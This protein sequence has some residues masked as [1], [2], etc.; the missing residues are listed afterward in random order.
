M[1]VPAVLVSLRP[2]VVTLVA[3]DDSPLVTAPRNG[4]AP[5]AVAVLV[6]AP[7]YRSAVVTVY[8]PEEQVVVPPGARV[9]VWHVTGTPAAASNS[10]WIPREFTTVDPVFVTTNR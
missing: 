1:I 6:T 7:E 8:T 3:I 2:A 9:V 4:A 5:V 10:S